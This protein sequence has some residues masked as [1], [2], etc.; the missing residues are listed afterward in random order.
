MATHTYTNPR[1]EAII[2][3]WPSGQHRTT[4]TFRIERDR[5]LRERA[6]RTTVDP[7][8]GRESKPKVLTYAHTARIV[9]GDDGRTYILELVA[10]GSHIRVVQSNMQYE[11]E[12][13]IFPR[14]PRYAELLALLTASV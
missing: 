9:D 5:T 11:A 1:L 10:G 14:D 12:P 7:R 4:A 6:T 13:A 2:P 3:D 8:T